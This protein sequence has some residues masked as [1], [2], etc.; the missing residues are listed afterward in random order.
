MM[1]QRDY[2]QLLAELAEDYAR[3]SPK[4]A[5][6]QARAEKSLVDG[7][8]HGM[9]MIQPFAPRVVSARGAWVTDA[10]GHRILDFWQGHFANLLGHNPEV[11]TRALTRGLEDGAALQ[12]GFPESF[13]VEAAELLCR[14]TGAE[15]ARFTTS[16]TLATMYAIMLTR[17]FTGRQ[18]VLKVGGG[19]H[20]GQPWSL[21]AVHFRDP[22]APWQV[23][24]L[25]L[26]GA[27]ADEVIVT[28]YNDTERLNDDFRRY[29]DR[30]ACFIV[31]PF[32]GG[33]GCVL[34][35]PEYLRAARELTQKHGALLILD[36][37]MSGFRFRAGDAGQLYGVRADLAVFG[38]IIGG[39]M[40]I[41]AVVG[42]ADIMNLCGRPGGRKVGF[43]GGTFSSH[44]GTMLAARTLLAHV[45]EH[46][47]EIYPRLAAMGERIR[48][49]IEQA[50]AR[51][52]IYARCTG[53]P[54][55]AILGSSMALVHFPYE[56]G[57]EIKR[58][59]DV[60]DPA[61]C[62][63]VLRDRVMQLA[64]LLDDIF[65]MFPPGA[66]TDAH[67]DA[68]IDRFLDACGRIARRLEGHPRE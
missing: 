63:V 3:H 30:L 61:V 52:G 59:E 19:W 34:A 58:S 38:K 15:R 43:H 31:E 36:E 48:R 45:A 53:G 6:L 21:K 39:G 8:S 54:N 14:L 42:R 1:G 17:G 50:F 13:E 11:I 29:G 10:D 25:G 4:S 65:V 32:V 28:R 60:F 44:V 7:G 22:A 18:L 57:R 35:D 12:T 9:R 40:P 46:E 41:A 33:G 68:D 64:M 37:V 47:N 2:T 26:P 56:P 55:G 27:A 51:Q 49:G 5:A 16:G 20:G 66:V 23:E 67:S 24:S 62:D